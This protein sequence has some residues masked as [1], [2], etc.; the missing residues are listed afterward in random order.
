MMIKKN[1]EIKVKIV[2]G[3]RNQ[4]ISCEYKTV[5][6][7]LQKIYKATKN[8]QVILYSIDFNHMKKALSMLINIMGIQIII[9]SNEMMDS[10]FLQL[11]FPYSSNLNKVKMIHSNFYL[12]ILLNNDLV[13]KKIMKNKI[14]WKPMFN[15]FMKTLSNKMILSNK[16]LSVVYN[17]T[18]IEKY[19]KINHILYLLKIEYTECILKAFNKAYFNKKERND[20]KI[21]IIAIHIAKI[22]MNICIKNNK[23]QW[24]LKWNDVLIGNA[25][26]IIWNVKNKR[27]AISK[28][29]WSACTHYERKLEMYVK[30]T[31][32]DYS[33]DD[34][35][36]KLE[37][38]KIHNKKICGNI[39]CKRM[40][41]YTKTKKL[42]ICKACQMTYY[43]CRS[44]QKR[45]WK[46]NHRILC[47]QWRHMKEFT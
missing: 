46:Y 21:L 31:K 34:L 26:D 25:F 40:N 28:H 17:I 38:H 35:G 12:S 19:W 42:S 27:K 13:Y 2:S 1:Y 7:F 41:I 32:L 15:F 39:N 16:F 20:N 6:V 23:E 37:T 36:I 22:F 44:C 24:F 10:T 8:D 5:S 14:A 45:D 30:A 29:L 9:D 11:L 43:C 3:S 33:L 18:K 47:K 4:T